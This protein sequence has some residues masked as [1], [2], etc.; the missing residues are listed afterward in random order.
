MQMKKSLLLFLVGSLSSLYAFVPQPLA[1]GDAV[2]PNDVAYYKH[3]L[4]LSNVELIYTKKNKDFAQLS[5]QKEA[6]INKE[7]EKL[8]DWKF[9][10]T[11]YVGLIS[12]HN[13]VANGFSTQWPNNRQINYMG[14][15]QLID[16][17]TTT[18]WLDT[19][20][21][22]ETAHNYQINVKGSR[23][24]QTLHFVFGNGI[25]LFPL[26]LIMPNVAINPFMLEG[27]AVLNESWHGNGGRLYS[28]RLKAQTLLQAKANQLTPEYLYNKKFAFPYGEI[29]YIQG[30]FYNYYLAKEYGL[31]K[32]NSFFKRS[33]EYWYWPFMTNRSMQKSIGRSFEATIEEFAVEQK[34]EAKNFHLQTGKKIA[35]S[36]FFSSLNNSKKE[37]FFLTNESGVRKP[38][39]VVLNKKSQEVKKIQESFLRGKVIKVGGEYFTQ[40]SAKTSPLQIEQGLFDKNAFIQEGSESKMIQGYLSNSNAV[41]F[42]VPS[43]FSQPQLY[44]GK[45]FYDQVNSSV[46]IDKKDNLYYF[47]QKNKIRTLYKNKRALFSYEGFYG[48]VSDVDTQGR[49]YF[50]ANSA[51]GSSLYRYTKGSI[52]RVSRADNVIE[53]RLVNDKE[54][55]VAAIDAN[56]YYYVLSPL[57]IQEQKPFNTKLFFEDEKY[58]THK[59][60]TNINKMDLG[61]QNKYKALLDM[62]Y[63]G[64]NASVLYSSLSG[65]IGSLNINFADP[66]MQNSANIFLNRDDTNVTI[67]GVGYSS[68]EYLLNYSISMYGVLDKGTRENIRDNGVIA[69]VTLPFLEA[70]YY[71]GDIQ[72][73]YFQDYDTKE[74]EP[75][76]ISVHLSKKEQYGVSFYA[77]A[78]NAITLYGVQDRGDMLVGGEYEFKHDL[79][80]EF[81]FGSAIKYSQSNAQSNLQKRGVKLSALSLTSDRDP[82]TIAIASLASSYYLKSAGYIE[83]N[84]AKVM[85]FSAYFFTF[86]LSLRREALYAKYRYYDLEDFTNTHAFS[87]EITAGI[88][89]SSVILNSFVVPISFEYVHSDSTLVSDENSVRVLLGLSF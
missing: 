68:S 14:G 23:V 34:K 70:G 7:Y 27:N 47:K 52:E 62:H 3:K 30:G 48:I 78:L 38:E 20:L 10:E 25:V 15:T 35:S 17:F 69:N 24:S 16:Y 37:I 4:P 49:V 5:G 26:P 67:A 39:L 54:L 31:Q 63:S 41:Y 81:Y 76:S 46:I 56:E 83:A 12:Q 42:D 29:A 64:S 8:F 74:R 75:L 2:V 32:S 87:N 22:H 82:S 71:Y 80:K 6:S 55:L 84:I 51:L 1:S 43:S 65:V 19:L 50:I 44:V 28:G 36:Q 53:A 66:L 88:T 79:A 11:L 77:N 61:T 18:S 21:Y 13:Q 60:S 58:N 59:K 86:P 85:H 57:Q 45:K 72:A 73:S 40:A 33:S 9:D 89:L